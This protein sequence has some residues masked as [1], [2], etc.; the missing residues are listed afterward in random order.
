MKS[1]YLKKNKLKDLIY[2]QENKPCSSKTVEGLF[3]SLVEPILE[4]NAPSLVLFRLEQKTQSRFN[5]LLKRLEFSNAQVFDFSDTKI[6]D[7]FKNILK[8]KVWDKTEFAYVLSERFGAVLIFDYDECEIE[9]CASIY[10]LHNSKKL[11]DAFNIINSNS[12]FDLTE[13]NEKFHPDRRDNDI[14][15]SSIRKIVSNLNDSNTEVLISEMDKD[16][17]EEKENLLQKVNFFSEKTRFVSHEIRNQLSICKLYS[18]IIKKRIDQLNITDE[19][20]KNSI[21]NATDCIIQATKMIDNSLLDMKSINNTNLQ[22]L[23]LKELLNKAK[24]LSAVYQ[25]DKKIEIK[26]NATNGIT[27]YAD[28][29]K[30]LA[31]IINLI[32]NAIESIEKTGKIT[33]LSDNS[34]DIISVKITNNGGKSIPKGIQEHIFDEGF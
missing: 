7:N 20:V 4:E 18:T 30:F 34:K 26:V 1:V 10:L 24:S 14:L 29:N 19:K 15:N 33:I 22:N 16:N 9:K 28:E 25:K 12:K 8:E 3:R 13:E 6:N 31:V 23:D 27:I 5:G 21:E 2:I 11:S 17:P 32:K